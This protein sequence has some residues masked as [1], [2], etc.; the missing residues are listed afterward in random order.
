M[1]LFTTHSNLRTILHGKNSKDDLYQ[2]WRIT[3]A[4]IINFAVIWN[5][6]GFFFDVLFTSCL[7]LILLNSGI[8]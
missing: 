6:R 4:T 1:Y 3:Y 5:R 8:F 2:N 7:S